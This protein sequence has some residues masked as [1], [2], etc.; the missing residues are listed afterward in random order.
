[1]VTNSISESSQK[2][3]GS[4]LPASCIQ[5]PQPPLAQRSWM[6]TI[7]TSRARR[8]K[9]EVRVFLVR[10][11]AAISGR[12]GIRNA[13][14]RPPPAC[15]RLHSL[16]CRAGSLCPRAA[17]PTGHMHL[18]RGLG[19][20]GHADLRQSPKTVPVSGWPLRV[21]SSPLVTLQTGPQTSG[22]GV[23]QAGLC[24]R[25]PQQSEELL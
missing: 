16:L 10:G 17:R 12:A 2:T 11:H 3:R 23:Q 19:A 9:G 6:V 13:A 24:V 4:A 20:R 8:W 25:R 21:K 18:G 22:H 15:L 1:M 14:A 7:P 5:S